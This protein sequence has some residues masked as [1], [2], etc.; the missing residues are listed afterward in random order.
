ML[1]DYDKDY[2]ATPNVKFYECVDCKKDYSADVEGDM[3]KC[4]ECKRNTFSIYKRAPYIEDV[5][6]STFLQEA[7]NG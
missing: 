5:R 4:G 7:E 2:S 3:W 1:S 6:S